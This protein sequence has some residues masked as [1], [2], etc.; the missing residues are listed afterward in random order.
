[1]PYQFY[2]KK[3]SGQK[4][5]EIMLFT[6][7]TCIWCK[8]TKALLNDLGLEYSY[9]DVDLLFGRDQEEAYEVMHKFSN[10]TSFPTIII[11]N[12]EEIIIGFEED[13]IKSLK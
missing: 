12:G 9:V 8:K 11:N 2:I 3:V 7:S 6:L 10:S 1:M 5:K 4:T 13:K